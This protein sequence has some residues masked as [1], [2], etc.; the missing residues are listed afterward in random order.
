MRRLSVERFIYK[1]NLLRDLPIALK[2]LSILLIDVN[3][4]SVCPLAALKPLT[5]KQ[6]PIAASTTTPIAK[7]A[8]IMYGFS[9]TCIF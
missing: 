8:I 3:D 7:D 4:L 9:K 2:R 6:I 5:A 1:T